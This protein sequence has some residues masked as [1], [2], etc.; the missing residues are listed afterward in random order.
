MNSYISV[1]ADQFVITSEKLKHQCPKRKKEKVST[2]YKNT[3]SKAS[4]I[5]AYF[6]NCFKNHIEEKKH[7]GAFTSSAIFLT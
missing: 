4:P 7:L 1:N 2:C 6:L 5:G 3:T